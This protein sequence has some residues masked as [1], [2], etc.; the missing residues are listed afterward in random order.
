MKA[1]EVGAVECLELGFPDCRG[2]CTLNPH[3]VE[4]ITADLA[5]MSLDSGAPE[6]AEGKTPEERPPTR[7]KARTHFYP[8]MKFK[9]RASRSI[10][11]RRL[12]RTIIPKK[13]FPDRLFWPEKAE[14]GH[15]KG[16]TPRPRGFL[17]AG[18]RA[19]FFFL[20]AEVPGTP[21]R[22]GR[23]V[24]ARAAGSREAS[25][26]PGP[27]VPFGSSSPKEMKRSYLGSEPEMLNTI[28]PI[29]EVKRSCQ[30]EI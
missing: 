1:A 21:W 14:P 19:W 4:G 8:E 27:P 6:S 12:R 25:G 18:V 17:S 23:R 7:T 15:R 3:D 28:K 30:G 22:C 24:T 20:A 5:A 29:Q 9:D 16:L 13:G 2:C 10:P 11:P 26:A